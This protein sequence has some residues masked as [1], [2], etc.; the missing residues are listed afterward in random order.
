MRIGLVSSA[1]PLVNGGGR[2]IV[3]WARAHL[4]A[5]GHE[6]ELFFLPF[7]ETPETMFDQIAAYRLIDLTQSCD[8]IVTFRPPAHVIEHPNKIAWFIHHIRGFYD[9]WDTPYAAAKNDPKGRALRDR[10]IATDTRTLGECRRIF[11]N[12]QV[13]SDRLA[14]FN[15]LAST[16]LY[17]PIWRPERFRPGA[18]GDEIV[19]V[20]RVEAHKRQDLLIDAMRHVST[21]VKLRICGLASN[22]EFAASLSAKIKEG[23]LGDRVA[24][25]NRWISEEEKADIIEN[26]LAVAYLPLD[27]DSYGYPSLEGAHAEKAIVTAVDSGGTLELVQDGRNGFISGADPRAVAAAFDALHADKSRA[28][29]MGAE[30]RARLHE[31]RIDWDRVTEALTS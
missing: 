27:E 20:C 23:G 30:S 15:G 25:E 29:R 17:P 13:V 9:L 28:R 5:S 1:V 22:P 21:G 4:Q 24:F 14:R 31:L 16:P 18:Y 6:V 11:T 8:R 10:M 7:V 3:E 19:A 12:S 2:F 26:A